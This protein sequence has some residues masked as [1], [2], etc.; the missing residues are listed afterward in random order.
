M[1]TGELEQEKISQ[2]D[3]HDV[4]DVAPVEEVKHDGNG[5]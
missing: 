2:Q 4:P 5:K 1:K 3:G